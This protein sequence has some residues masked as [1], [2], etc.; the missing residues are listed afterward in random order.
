M[1][2]KAMYA[3]IEKI[4]SS[5]NDDETVVWTGFPDRNI[6]SHK[7]HAF[8][9]KNVAFFLTAGAL[10]LTNAF[11]KPPQMKAV[12]ILLGAVAIVRL[13][14]AVFAWNSRKDKFNMAYALTTKRLI[15]VNG[16]T[17]EMAS[18]Y[19]PSIKSMQLKRS[20]HTVS[21]TLR[22]LETRFTMQLHYIQNFKSLKSLLSQFSAEN[23]NM[24]QDNQTLS[25]IEPISTPTP[26][27]TEFKKAA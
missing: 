12:F 26:Q 3:A 6:V 23:A 9:W 8:Y 7:V 24:K 16:S 20:K 14:G 15:S 2:K 11:M 1:C 10:A 19:N 25:S 18:W 13:I 21:F 4:E 22:D 5:V 17:D 27:S